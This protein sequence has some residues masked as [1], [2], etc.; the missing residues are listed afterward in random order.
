MACEQAAAVADWGVADSAPG[1]MGSFA[2]TVALPGSGET[3][4]GIRMVGSR[5]AASPAHATSSSGRQSDAGAVG[6]APVGA[7]T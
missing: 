6:L 2:E 3:R 4:P 7:A 5:A 1:R